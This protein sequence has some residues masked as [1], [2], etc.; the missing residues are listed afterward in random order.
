V[1]IAT[2]GGCVTREEN[3]PLL[4]QNG[5]L[6]WL[7]RGLEKLPTDGR[8]ISMSADLGELYA[9]RAP[10]YARWADHTVSNDAAPENTLRELLA[11]LET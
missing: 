6:I 7:R 8:P 10:L 2:G 3:Y 11:V 4:H 1:V 9:R 5:V